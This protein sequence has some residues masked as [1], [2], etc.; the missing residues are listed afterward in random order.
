[1]FMM[2]FLCKLVQV[3]DWTRKLLNGYIQHPYVTTNAIDNYIVPSSFG[4]HAGM[5]G[6]LTL[7]HLAYEEAGGRGR[8]AGPATATPVD[9]GKSCG[10]CPCPKGK[11]LV[12]CLSGVGMFALG[13]I[14]AL[15]ALKSGK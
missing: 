2:P 11:T 6:C 1:M 8:G 12:W 4:Q 7:A 15:K 13:A 10:A 5:V 3:R 14:V 9:S